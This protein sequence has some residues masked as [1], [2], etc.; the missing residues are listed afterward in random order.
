MLCRPQGH[1][2]AGMI[3]SMKNSNKTIGNRSRDLPV[4]TTVPQ[5]LRHSAP[6]PL[7][8]TWINTVQPDTP[9]MTIRHMRNAC[10]VTKATNTHWEYVIFIAFPL[11]LLLHERGSMLRYSTSPVL[12]ATVFKA[13]WW[14]IPIETSSYWI[15]HSSGELNDVFASTYRWT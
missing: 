12:F 10:C 4:C 14:S 13:R 2:A 7:W 9:P 15:K 8:S 11:Q 5:P 6:L 1:S 3:M